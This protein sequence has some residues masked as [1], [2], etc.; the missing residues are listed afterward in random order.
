MP[1]PDAGATLIS[2]TYCI[3]PLRYVYSRQHTLRHCRHAMSAMPYML[4]FRRYADAA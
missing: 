2:E 3:T 4:L 1:P